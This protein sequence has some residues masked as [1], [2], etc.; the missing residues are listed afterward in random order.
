MSGWLALTENQRREA[1]QQA[2]RSSGISPK[3]IEKDWWV[4]LVLRAL[5]EGPYTSFLIFKG[6]TSLSKCWNLIDRFSEDI[7]IALDP[8]AFGMP[9]KPVPTKGDVERLKRQG[10]DFTSKELK[11]ALEMQ[12]ARM[13]V[14]ADITTVTAEEVIEKMPDKDPQILSIRYPS[15]YETSHYLK[16][17]VKVE[18]SVRSL[19][20]PFSFRSVQSILYTYFP[21]DAYS[22]TALEIPSVVPRKTFLEKA[23]LL[24]EEFLKPDLEKIKTGRMSRHL[25]DLYRLTQSGVA[26]DALADRVLYDTIIEHRRQYS[27]LKHVPYATLQRSTISFLPPAGLM[28]IYRQDYMFMQDQMIYGKPP[29][30]EEMMS[31]MTELLEKFRRSATS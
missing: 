18:V 20:E 13:G 4:T 9:Y 11:V 24:H 5:F 29:T 27:R 25:Y 15:L 19:K 10:C 3:A 30:F 21:N 1:L 8:T 7:D 26:D 2:S 6:G 12:L 23:F 31:G 17:E 22:E 16:D 14:Q 28:E